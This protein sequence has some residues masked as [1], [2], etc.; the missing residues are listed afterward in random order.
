M[1][2]ESSSSVE[3]ENRKLL[4]MSEDYTAAQQ[5]GKALKVILAHATKDRLK[6]SKNKGKTIQ[7]QKNNLQ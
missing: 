1:L 2:F 5:S 7:K 3:K 6:N 4:F